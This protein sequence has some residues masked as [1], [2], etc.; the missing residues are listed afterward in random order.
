MV[1]CFVPVCISR[2]PGKSFGQHRLNQ[3]VLVVEKQHRGCWLFSRFV[4]M[5][6]GEVNSLRSELSDVSIVARACLQV[7]GGAMML[8]VWSCPFSERLCQQPLS[9]R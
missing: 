6:R 7:V 3:Y 5:S 9:S 8:S 1:G 2:L 4:S